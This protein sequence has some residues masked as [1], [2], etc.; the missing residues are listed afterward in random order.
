V[1]DVQPSQIR[2]GDTERESALAA[3]GE[4]M[5]AGRLD[6]DE[7]GDRTA[8]VSTAKTRGELVDLF[9]DLPQPHPS[10]G[11]APQPVAM[12]A[13]QSQ[14][15]PVRRGATLNQRLAA[16]AVP[17]AAIVALA[18]FFAV[19]WWVVFLIPAAVTLFGGAIWGED[20]KH[21][22]RLARERY[23]QERRE[24]RRRGRGW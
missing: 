4:H 5:S 19:H 11:V 13:Q 24:I 2:I 15:V 18:L 10:F 12:P 21:N 20:W 1:A 3:L 9:G 23:R 7:Y 6:I 17:A 22:K 8:R 16:V 14:A